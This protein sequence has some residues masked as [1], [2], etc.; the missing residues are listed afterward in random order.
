MAARLSMLLFSDNAKLPKYIISFLLC[1]LISV[2]V[3]GLRQPRLPSF[4]S[5]ATVHQMSNA[6]HEAFVYLVHTDRLEE[7]SRS[8]L[9]LEDNFFKIHGYVRVILFHEPWTQPDLAAAMLMV[10]VSLTDVDWIV[11]NDFDRKPAHYQWQ[12]HSI[13]AYW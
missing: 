1:L 6:S 3:Q 4:R 13:Q 2:P 12:N 10:P 8:L 5:I 7:L 9:L 11:L